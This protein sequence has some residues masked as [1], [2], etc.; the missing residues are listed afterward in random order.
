[1]KTNRKK[2]VPIKV[3]LLLST[4]EGKH[5]ETWNVSFDDKEKELHVSEFT[6]AFP[7]G[8]RVAVNYVYMHGAGEM[9]LGCVVQW[10][11]GL[12]YLIWFDVD[13]KV[14]MIDGIQLKL[15]RQPLPSSFPLKYHSLVGLAVVPPFSSSS[16]SSSPVDFV[17]NSNSQ[18]ET[19]G[20][21]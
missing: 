13:Q 14:D 3:G 6:N 19:C 10:D 12:K 17:Y 1:M 18:C 4:V 9:L 21:K 15:S 8:Q 16:S 20:K 7:V 5:Q 2:K 11:G